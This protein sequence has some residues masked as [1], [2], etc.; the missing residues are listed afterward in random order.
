MLGMV[1]TMETA[2]TGVRDIAN[3]IGGGVREGSLVL[4]EGEAKAGKSVMS[5]YIAYGILSA[6]ESSVVYYSMDCDTEALM[7][8]MDSIALGVRP[9][10]SNDRLRVYVMESGK[11]FGNYR[12]YLRL[13]TDHIAGLPPRF[14]LVVVDSISPLMM[15]LKQ[16]HQMDFLNSFRELCDTGRSIVLTLNPH[17]FEAA[18]LARAYAM[19]D[20]YLKL[21]SNNVVLGAGQ[22]ETRNIKTMDVP[23]LA[24]AERRGQAGI[25]FEIKPGIGIQ[26]LPLVHVRI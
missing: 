4:I 6:K 25:K 21:Q 3:A 7:T 20:Y 8:N 22:V 17:V 11:V 26:I 9:F 14:K 13:I 19:S 1:T 15:R 24:G 5:Q 23:R 10:L 16:M 12:E 2:N 18:A